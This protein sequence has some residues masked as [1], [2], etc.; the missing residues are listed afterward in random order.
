MLVKNAFELLKALSRCSARSRASA[1]LAV[2]SANLSTSSATKI[3]TGREARFAGEL[4]P[5]NVRVQRSNCCSRL[6]IWSLSVGNLA[7]IAGESSSMGNQRDLENDRARFSLGISHKAGDGSTS[8]DQARPAISVV[9]LLVCD[10]QHNVTSETAGSFQH[11][12][13]SRQYG[14]TAVENGPGCSVCRWDR[15]RLR[16]A[17]STTDCRGVGRQSCLLNSKISRCRSVIRKAPQ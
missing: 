5:T 10:P 8:M 6:V 2:A 13:G 1:S 11:S 3:R 16:S 7:S 4:E 14:R 15:V 12:N 17:H 9:V